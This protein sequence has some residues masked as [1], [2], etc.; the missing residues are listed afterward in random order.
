M[1]SVAHEDFKA[2]IANLQ[3]DPGYVQPDLFGLF[4]A[5]T[6]RDGRIISGRFLA[7]NHAAN[8]GS[9]AILMQATNVM[10]ERSALGQREL[11]VPLDAASVRR[12]LECFPESIIEE[13]TGDKHLNVQAL[14]TM[15]YGEQVEG[16]YY[17]VF[18][19]DNEARVESIPAA[20]LK[21]TCNFQQTN[22]YMLYTDGL[23]DVLKPLVWAGERAFDPDD[24]TYYRSE[25]IAREYED[26]MNMLPPGLRGRIVNG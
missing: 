7:W 6:N 4:E 25:G 10:P 1:T 2:F 9:A 13:A 18:V 23:K 24:M 5:Q 3:R 20:L 22:H 8:F 14:L 21:L 15:R 26:E 11:V 19:F 17:A 16:L 12:A